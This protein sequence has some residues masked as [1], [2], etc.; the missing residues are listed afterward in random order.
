MQRLGEERCGQV[1]QLLLSLEPCPCRR[2]E[3]CPFTPSAERL[4]EQRLAAGFTIKQAAE[5]AGVSPSSVSK[6]EHGRG[7]QSLHLRIQHGYDT[8]MAERRRAARVT[9][10]MGHRF[11]KYLA[12]S[13]SDRDAFDRACSW[14][15]D[16]EEQHPGIRVSVD[17]P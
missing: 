5:A 16:V 1:S 11:E 4:R 12:L 8:V 15:L 9:D 14:A 6:A 2:G 3:R 10:E 7:T 13:D 17:L